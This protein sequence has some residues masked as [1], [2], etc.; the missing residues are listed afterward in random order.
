VRPEVTGIVGT[1]AG[2]HASQALSETLFDIG[3][4]RV[5]ARWGCLPPNVTLDPGT[6]DAV[7]EKSWLLDLDMFSAAQRPFSMDDLMADAARFA[8]RIYTIFRWA[9]TPAFLEHYGAPA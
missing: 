6:I 2:A 4:A 7:P 5:L 1:A 8:E 9:V 3:K